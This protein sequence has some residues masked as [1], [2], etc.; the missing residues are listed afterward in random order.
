LTVER[1]YTVDELSKALGVSPLTIGRW[2]RAKKL[3]GTKLGKQWRITE[4]D[5]QDFINKNRQ[6]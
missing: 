6:I 3:I 2:L 1:L 5:L 4:T